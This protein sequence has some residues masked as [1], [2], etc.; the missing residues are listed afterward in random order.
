MAD[1]LLRRKS[2]HD[3]QIALYRH[4]QH[5]HTRHRVLDSNGVHTT[6][7]NH[8]KIAADLVDVMKFRAGAIGPERAVCD[9]LDEKFVRSCKDELS[10]NRRRNVKGGPYQFSCAYLACL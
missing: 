3:A 6:P 10:A 2:A 8:L 4:I 1:I 9:A 7:G 5:V